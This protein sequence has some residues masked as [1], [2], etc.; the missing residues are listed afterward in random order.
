VIVLTPGIGTEIEVA[1]VLR[2]QVC[3]FCGV[4]CTSE[5]ALATHIASDN[6]EEEFARIEKGGR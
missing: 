2:L 4:W 5:A 3:R 1:Q 6:V